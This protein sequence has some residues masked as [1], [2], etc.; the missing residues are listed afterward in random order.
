VGKFKRPRAGLAGIFA[1]DPGRAPRA[2]RAA[3]AGIVLI[4]E[5]CTV[6]VEALFGGFSMSG[7][8]RE[9]PCK[10][11]HIWNTAMKLKGES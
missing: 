8:G 10:H 9:A 1:A 2:A 6:G 4:D 5:R 7:H 3:R 11:S